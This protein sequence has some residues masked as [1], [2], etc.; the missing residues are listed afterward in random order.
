MTDKKQATIRLCSGCIRKNYEKEGITF[1][2]LVDELNARLAKRLPNHQLSLQR[3]SC[4]RFCPAQRIS[5][6]VG[7]QL[8]MSQHATLDS[9]LAEILS[10][11]ADDSN[12]LGHQELIQLKYR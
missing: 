8:T 11:L 9:M 2:E 6:S 4:F 1:E 5:M 3:Q 12:S 7:G 10:V